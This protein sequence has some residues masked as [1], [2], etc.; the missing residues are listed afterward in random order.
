M[1][2]IRKVNS[3][4]KSWKERLVLLPWQHLLVE[5]RSQILL[6]Y[7]GLMTCFVALAVPCIYYVLFREI[8]HRVERDLVEEVQEF[9]DFWA[10]Q[11]P[12]SLNHMKQ[13]MFRYRAEELIEDDQF[14]IFIAEQQLYLS[15]PDPL[16]NIMQAESPLMTQWAQTQSTTNGMWNTRSKALGKLLYKAEPITINAQV[17]GVFVIA[18]ST[19]GERAEVGRILGIVLLIMLVILFLAAIVAWV[20]SARILLPLRS[21]SATARSISESD[22]SQRIAVQGNGELAEVAATFND[23]MDRLQ[24][25]FTSQRDFVRDASHELR[26]PITIIQG[27]L[28]LMGDDPDEQRE[29][30][31]LVQDEL[32]RMNRFVTEIL[33]LA[34]SEHPN[35]IQ[36]EATDLATL[37]SEIYIKA[38]VIAKCHCQLAQSGQGTVWLDRQ[39]ITQAIL[40]LVENA[41]QHTPATGCITLGSGIQDHHIRFWV[42]DTGKGVSL[43]DQRRIFE[44]F[45]R[46][47]NQPRQSEGA[48]LGLS[49][50]HAIAHASGG[51]IELKSTV[52][53][54]STFTLV[55]PI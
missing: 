30:L 37:T 33:T 36:P 49:I 14:L 1:Q 20:I 29:V 24:L 27:H 35:F 43:Y 31:A 7:I 44:P 28:D 45:S 4:H 19:S 53:Q 47:A 40:N 23:M 9:R 22:L 52:G 13:L 17:R 41:N 54:G 38:K 26:T 3:F 25:A 39:R 21:L 11:S 34:K 32:N 50:V 15:E 2:I 12:D 5:T 46:A 42:T 8:D 51:S 10:A 18:R 55:V 16:P 6:C 48:G